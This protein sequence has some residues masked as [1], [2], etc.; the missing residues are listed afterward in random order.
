MV[1]SRHRLE[2]LHLPSLG[3]TDQD[4]QAA[5]HGSAAPAG[6]TAAA[7][8][9]LWIVWRSLTGTQR[10]ER[11]NRLKAFVAFAASALPGALAGAAFL[12][13]KQVIAQGRPSTRESAS[14]PPQ[15]PV[16]DVT[17]PGVSALPAVPGRPSLAQPL[18]GVGQRGVAGRVALGGLG[19]PGY[20]GGERPCR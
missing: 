5:R 12:W 18:Q 11:A 9:L 17:A 15:H 8:D 7:D 10:D 3:L 19:Q 1:E 4:L 6:R 20:V 16:D 13:S 2:R 14:A